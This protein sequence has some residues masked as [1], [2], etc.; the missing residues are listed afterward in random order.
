MK[1][2]SVVLLIL[3]AAMFLFAGCSSDEATDTV[4]VNGEMNNPN[5]TN[6]PIRTDSLKKKDKPSYKETICV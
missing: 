6:N 4:A 1:K 2:L 5:N 3:L